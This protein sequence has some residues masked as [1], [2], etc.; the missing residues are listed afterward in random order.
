LRQTFEVN[1]FILQGVLDTLKLKEPF[2]SF[3]QSNSPVQ[4]RDQQ[5]LTRNASVIWQV[6]GDYFLISVRSSFT[7]GACNMLLIN[8]TLIMY[9]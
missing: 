2:G 8:V 6:L 7:R 9:L 1:G 3:V 5:I 4:Q